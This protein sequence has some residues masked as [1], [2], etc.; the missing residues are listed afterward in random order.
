MHINYPTGYWIA[1][2]TAITE[3]DLIDIV[4]VLSQR[5]ML[6]FASTHRSTE[7]HEYECLCYCEDYF[8]NI[9]CK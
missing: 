2:K 1:K 9:T 4:H 6:C 7:A 5:G 3:V 8:S